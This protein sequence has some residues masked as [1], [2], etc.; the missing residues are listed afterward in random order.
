MYNMIFNFTGL[1]DEMNFGPTD[2]ITHDLREMR[3]TELYIDE[4]AE[5][6]LLCLIGGY[7]PNG[8]HLLDNGN[9]HYVTRLF[10][11]H[12][13]ED[14][15]LI[16]CDN[17]SDDQPPA[18]EGIKS[19]GSWVMDAR[20][21]LSHRMKSTCWINGKGEVIINGVPSADRPVYLSIDK[22]VLD[23]TVAPTNW[24]QGSLQL[25]QLLDLIEK[26]LNGR[27][28]TG[29]DICG[30]CLYENGRASGEDIIEN[31]KVDNYLIDYFFQKIKAE[32]HG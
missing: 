6:K 7:G 28:L 14:F 31:E 17:H 20:S 32:N 4:E 21:E 29:V 9:Y 12:I 11:H 22:D 3:G 25:D 27:T 18:F 24:D 2:F 26:Q 8:I 19:C 30:E 1:Y 16:Y 15:D 23:K 13:K 5:E 10:L